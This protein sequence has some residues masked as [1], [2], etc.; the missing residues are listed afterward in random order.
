MLKKF[1]RGDTRKIKLKFKDKAGSNLNLSGATIYLT[2]K[3]D[4]AL[5]DD[6]S[7]FQKI[8][9]NHSNPLEG[10]TTIIIDPSDTENLK[11]KKYYYDIQLTDSEGNKSTVIA[12]QFEL[13]ADVTRS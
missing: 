1:Y 8:I 6:Q 13:M 3:N 9:T 5:D 10:E 12:G 7:S 4:I 2:V 11:P